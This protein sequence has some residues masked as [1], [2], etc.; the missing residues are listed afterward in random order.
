[1]RKLQYLPTSCVYSNIC[2]LRHQSCSLT[3]HNLW[4]SW[5]GLSF[6][7]N[8]LKAYWVLSHAWTMVHSRLS[9]T[10]TNSS[11]RI[12]H[13]QF[14]LPSNR[15]DV[16]F[17][18]LADAGTR[19]VDPRGMKGWVDLVRAEVRI[20]PRLCARVREKCEASTLTTQPRRNAILLCALRTH[21]EVLTL[22]ERQIR[23]FA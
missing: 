4:N 13:T 19:L 11:Y 6:K 20:E 7:A 9:T 12:T 10:R 3:Q 18:T 14:C 5:T 2:N 8:Q 16:P 15:G 22:V 21:Y 17:I 23:A 1:M